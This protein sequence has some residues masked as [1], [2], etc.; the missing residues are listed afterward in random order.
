MTGIPPDERALRHH[1]AGPR[2]QEGVRRGRW[3]LVGDVSWPMVLVAVA[4]SPR[5]NAPS[6]YVLRFDLTGYPETAPTATPWN[7][8]IENVAAQDQRPKGSLVGHVFRSDWEE[9]KALYAPFDRVALNYHPEWPKQYPHQAWTAAR[10]LA[11]V[12]QILHEM[13]N[14]DDYTGV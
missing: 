9:G 2:F 3:R 14:N 10:D 4:A 7:L 6:E 13:L 12:L 1:L 8:S 5:D 11:W